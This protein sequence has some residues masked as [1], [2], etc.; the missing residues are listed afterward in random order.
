MAHWASV[1]YKQ[2]LALKPDVV[3]VMLGTNDA[4]EWCYT[5]NSGACPGGTSK[6]YASD[7]HNVSRNRCQSVARLLADPHLCALVASPTPVDARLHAAAKRQE[8]AP[9]D[10]APVPVPTGQCTNDGVPG[11]SSL[12]WMQSLCTVRLIATKGVNWS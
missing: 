4:D 5:Q 10:P 3:I 2:S 1:Q 9:D 11:E 7:L 12:W 6:H 8:D